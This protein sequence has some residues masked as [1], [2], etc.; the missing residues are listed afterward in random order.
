MGVWTINGAVAEVFGVQDIVI[1]LG[2]QEAD[3]A[4]LVFH[5]DITVPFWAYDTAIEIKLDGVTKFR[6][7]LEKRVRV[8]TSSGEAVQWTVVGPWQRM[9]TRVFEE[10]NVY[11]NGTYVS[12]RWYI[13]AYNLK[14]HV[15]NLLDRARFVGFLLIGSIDL[16]TLQIPVEEVRDLSIAEGIRRCLRWVPGAVVGFDHSTNPPTCNIRLITYPE[17]I[18]LTPGSD[19]IVDINLTP[20]DDLSVPNVIIA[21]ERAINTNTKTTTYPALQSESDAQTFEM[22][23]IDRAGT[24]PNTVLRKSVFN[25]VLLSGSKRRRIVK[26]Q[27]GTWSRF[28][29]LA[30]YLTH[31]GTTYPN[32]WALFDAGPSWISQ[33]GVVV[34]SIV[35]DYKQLFGDTPASGA[36]YSNRFIRFDNWPPAFQPPDELWRSGSFTSGFEVWEANLRVTFRKTSTG[37]TAA[38]SSKTKFVGLYAYSAT[39]IPGALRDGQFITRTYNEQDP[40]LEAAPTGIAQSIYDH[41]AGFS[42]LN[43][44]GT[45]VLASDEPIAL[46]PLVKRLNVVGVGAGVIQR[47][48]YAA[49]SG[50][51]TVSLGTP[52]H[53]GP[54][55]FIALQRLNHA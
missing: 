25:T 43:Y 11:E 8:A 30:Y 18:T 28:Y 47:V 45:V 13:G 41:L 19:K 37:E 17:T 26:F 27:Q 35:E 54:Q 31:S 39:S 51:T 4:Q 52:R 3:E 53:L 24:N 10:A 15:M 16:P 6:G 5:S 12:T 1:R 20:R 23:S 21:Y 38:L 36:L 29:T 9:E 14:Q 40:V 22:V 7:W 44:E 33:S 32:L 48:V 46:S 34:D 2:N 42:S 55:D 50:R 49:S